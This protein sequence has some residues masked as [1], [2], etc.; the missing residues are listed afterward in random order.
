M[1]HVVEHKIFR[2]SWELVRHTYLVDLGNEIDIQQVE[3]SPSHDGRILPGSCPRTRFFEAEVDQIQKGGKTVFSFRNICP[4]EICQ[5]PDWNPFNL[6]RKSG[7]MRITRRFQS[8]EGDT[9]IR[10]LY[11]DDFFLISLSSGDRHDLE[12]LIS[13]IIGKLNMIALSVQSGKRIRSEFEHQQQFRADMSTMFS[14]GVDGAFRD[15]P[16]YQQ[17]GEM[18]ERDID[19]S[20]ALMSAEF[21]D[22]NASVAAGWNTDAE[23]P[24]SGSTPP[25]PAATNGIPAEEAVPESPVPEPQG[26]EI[27]AAEMAKAADTHADES[28]VAESAAGDHAGAAGI[29]A[30]GCTAEIIPE[31]NIP[32]TEG[33]DRMREDE[34]IPSAIA[35]APMEVTP[36]GILPAG[37]SA[38]MH[39][40]AGK[41]CDSCGAGISDSTK[42]CGRCGTAVGSTVLPGAPV[43][44][45][46]PADGGNTS[47]PARQEKV[48]VN[49]KSIKEL[50]D[51][52]W[53]S[54]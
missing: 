25:V 19:V 23:S 52:S 21:Q 27:P 1:T 49:L 4:V 16:V 54:D 33:L 30:E 20:A 35:T 18:T 46:L 38:E 34:S 28:I 42:F 3:I 17:H 48:A 37:E 14:K 5:K 44:A 26:T 31:A 13:L 41:T 7:N 29:S 24:N 6:M 50:E 53:L 12:M 45:A 8:Q 22:L 11:T 15:V 47:S 51:L 36:A 2:Y 39:P 43:G 10:W 32:L 40:P 9:E